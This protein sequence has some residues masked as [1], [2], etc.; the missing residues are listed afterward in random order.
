MRG[1]ENGYIVVETITCFILFVFLNI[2]IL[3]LI[4][5]VTVQ[6]R[7]YYALT[8]AA[9]AVSMYTYVL[10]VTGVASH[11]VTAPIRQRVWKRTPTP[12]N[13]TSIPS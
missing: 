3:S 6:A 5:I 7:V 2:S 10:D 9:E 13:P 1:D 11:M 8:Q 12:S 4:N